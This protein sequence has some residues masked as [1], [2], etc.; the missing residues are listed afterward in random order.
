MGDSGVQLPTR[1]VLVGECRDFD[2]WGGSGGCTLRATVVALLSRVK[3][4]QFALKCQRQIREALDAG[5]RA[6]KVIQRQ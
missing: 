5:H 4:V 2:S 1:A 6:A 3:E